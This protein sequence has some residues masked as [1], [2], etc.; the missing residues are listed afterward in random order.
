MAQRYAL[1]QAATLALSWALRCYLAR[2]SA[3]AEIARCVCEGGNPV[4]RLCARQ[5]TAVRA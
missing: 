4:C 2:L 1:S 3:E 5:L